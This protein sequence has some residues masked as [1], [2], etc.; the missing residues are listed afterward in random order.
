MGNTQDNTTSFQTFSQTIKDSDFIRAKYYSPG[1][2]IK[3]SVSECREGKVIKNSLEMRQKVSPLTP[4]TLESVQ[5]Q[6]CSK[7]DNESYVGSGTV[8]IHG[9]SFEQKYFLLT[10][11]HNFVQIER[12]LS[13]KISYCDSARYDY[14]KDGKKCFNKSWVTKYSIYP[15]YQENPSILCGYDLAIGVLNGDF[16]NAPVSRNSFWSDI[17]E[18]D[19]QIGDTICIIGYPGEYDG[20]LYKME[21]KIKKLEDVKGGN[22]L[23][24]YDSIDTSGGQSG[25][26]VYL[27]RDS[28]WYIIGLHVGFDKSSNVNVATAITKKAYKW[29]QQESLNL[30]K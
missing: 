2:Q 12:G 26:P 3:Q 21:G 23:I 4:G 6:I 17:E 19:A 5:G 11:A 16:K 29:M 27:K 1:L 9:N 10:C 20:V 30:F 22:K 28:K 18:S 8:N 14:S 15:G 13:E 7:I 25:S 24:L